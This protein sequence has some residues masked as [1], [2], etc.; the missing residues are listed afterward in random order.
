MPAKAEAGAKTLKDM[1]MQERTK[2]EDPI[3]LKV[4]TWSKG[5][6]T[7]IRALLSALPEVLWEGARFN[8]VSLGQLMEASAVKKSYQRAC[9]VVHPDRVRSRVFLVCAGVLGLSSFFSFPSRPQTQHQQ[10]SEH[11]QLAHEI[12][13]QLSLAFKAFEDSGAK[14]LV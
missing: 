2:T 13:V 7:N 14:S 12:F 4:E 5:R 1:L 3:K 8:A 6:E 11:A 9:L 10:G